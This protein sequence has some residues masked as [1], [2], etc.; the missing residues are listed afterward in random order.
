MNVW[1]VLCSGIQVLMCSCW[2][3]NR[4]RAQKYVFL[5]PSSKNNYTYFINTPYFLHS[6]YKINDFLQKIANRIYEIANSQ[7]PVR[8]LFSIC[9][10][11]LSICY[12]NYRKGR[13]GFTTK[14]TEGTQFFRRDGKTEDWGAKTDKWDARTAKLD[15][16]TE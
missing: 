4:F 2:Q 10:L 12:N 13:K 11:L 1:K 6:K 8:T 3:K 15:G 9:Y 16:K 5:H 14:G 7:Q